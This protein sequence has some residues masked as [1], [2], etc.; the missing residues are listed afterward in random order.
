M[1]KNGLKY[2]P[3]YYRKNAAVNLKYLH[4]NYVFYHTVNHLIIRLIPLSYIIIALN[5][6]IDSYEY[7]IITPQ[8][9]Y[10]NL[11]CRTW[12]HTT[13]MLTI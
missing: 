9:L 10:E 6:K 5:H 7:T 1:A 12:R 8:W 11:F 3:S 4:D 2:V 13:V